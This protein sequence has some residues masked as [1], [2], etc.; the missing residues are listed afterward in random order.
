MK[1]CGDLLRRHSR[2]IFLINQTAHRR[3]IS[4]SPSG[5]ASN[6]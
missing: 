3:T 5:I 1:T 4:V 6:T 2:E